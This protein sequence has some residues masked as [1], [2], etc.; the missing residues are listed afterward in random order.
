MTSTKRPTPTWLLDPGDRSTLA[1]IRH[2]S[3]ELLPFEGRPLHELESAVMELNLHEGKESIRRLRS[4]LTEGIVGG[5]PVEVERGIDPSEIRIQLFTSLWEHGLG[6]LAAN[7]DLFGN[8]DEFIAT[9]A[10]HFDVAPKVIIDSLY[11]DTPGERRVTFPTGETKA[12]D[13]EAIHTV[14]LI[15]LKQRLRRALGMTLVLPLTMK[16]NSPYVSI[17]WLLKREGLMYDG[18]RSGSAAH[19]SIS[20]PYALF[21]RTTAYANRLF[22]FCKSLFSLQGATWTATVDVITQTGE[23]TAQVAAIPLN[24]SMS[25]Y[26]VT[27]PGDRIAAATRSGDEGA[28]RKYFARF[29]TDWSLNYEG[30]LVPID[31]PE[32]HAH[33]F[34]VP[35]FVARHEGS[36][37]E[38][39]IEIVGYWRP[40]YLRR[41]L[42]KITLVKNRALILLVNRKLLLGQQEATALE[43]AGVHIFYYEGR[44]QLKETVRKV[45]Q[46][47]QG[48]SDLFLP[49]SG[50]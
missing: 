26:F 35:D 21:E 41:K 43:E 38:V 45:A 17:F 31:D 1:L 5:K 33:R 3:D 18:V 34:I 8:R 20:G 29:V 11:A 4:E 32:T 22:D 7:D 25:R 49:T 13:V 39:L 40:D 36:D 48:D 6:F 44:E 19:L 42:E 47:L 15:R 28:F 16:E 50:V 14:N 10:R 9:T 37:R 30:V 2:L 27:L 46:L 23:S 24:A 12:L